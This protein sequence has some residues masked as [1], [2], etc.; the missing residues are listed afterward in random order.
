MDEHIL[1]RL[2]KKISKKRKGKKFTDEQRLKH[3]ENI[4]NLWANE[5]WVKKIKKADRLGSKNPNWKGGKKKCKCGKPIS[6]NNKTCR[7]CYDISGEKNPFFNKKHNIETLKK[8]SN[9]RN[10]CGVNNPNFK[11]NIDINELK[12]LYINN[13][14]TIDEIKNI[15][16]CSRNTICNLLKN[17]NIIKEKS[18]KYNL[19]KNEIINY[20]NDGLNYVEI[21]KFYN[22][23]NKIIHK[24][25]KINKL[26]NVK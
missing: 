5:N 24:Y 13:N 19:N 9:N 6:K 11:Y 12:I 18:N 15:Y 17:N 25:I 4:K 16:G 3:K 10:Y 23:S 14:K 7:V 1:K 8:M 21:G 20:I 22:C 26:K 2:E